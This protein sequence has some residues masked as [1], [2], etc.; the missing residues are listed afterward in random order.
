MG[1]LVF[2]ADYPWKPPA[3]MMVTE[4][5]R[6]QTNAKIC[7]SIS[8][9]HPETWNP[10]WPIRSIIIGIISFMC[11]NQNTIGAISTTDAQKINVASESAAKLLENKKFLEVFEHMIDDI[12]IKE[13][14]NLPKVA[15][16]EQTEQI[17][18]IKEE[19]KPVENER[20]E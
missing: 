16:V 14:K 12:G 7:L 5:A 9:Y 6:F 18:Q 13:A 1:K 15:K 2:P 19:P 11:T 10:V 3:I 8:D 4:T 20:K 17:E